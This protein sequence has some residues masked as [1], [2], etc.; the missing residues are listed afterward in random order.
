MSN[1]NKNENTKPKSSTK[2]WAV[3]EEDYWNGVAIGWRDIP[4]HVFDAIPPGMI[5][6]TP[7]LGSTGKLVDKSIIY[8][9]E[10]LSDI[11]LEEMIE[12]YGDVHGFVLPDLN[13]EI[14][15]PNDLF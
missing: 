4:S 11:D 9:G 12:L 6:N 10:I 7:H 15:V 1:K 14:I 5:Y 2:R 8:L 3:V 13:I